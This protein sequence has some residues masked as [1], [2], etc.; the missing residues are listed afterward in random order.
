MPKRQLTRRQRYDKNLEA[1]KKYPISLA[2]V[3]FMFD[4]NIGFLIRSAA[5]FGISNIH[6]IGALPK[7]SKVN[8]SSGSLFDY[9]SFIQHD[10]PF[11]FLNYMKREGIKLISAEL[12]DEA[13]SIHDYEFYFDSN[14]CIG[15]GHET[16]GIPI[17]ILMNSD[18]IYIPMPGAGA[19][20]NTS[21]AANII[22]YEAIRQFDRQESCLIE[23]G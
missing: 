23:H 6:V 16:Y 18:K 12:C 21:Q 15:A 5:C 20:L 9:V 11:K 2:C 10:N 13:V 14:T 19:C 17:E 22:L 7:R 4:E 1:S 8:A 3:N